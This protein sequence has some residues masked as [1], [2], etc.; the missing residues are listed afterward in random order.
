MGKT[1]WMLAVTYENF[2]ITRQNGFGTQGVEGSQRRKAARFAPDDRLLYYLSDRRAFAATATIASKRF[3]EH[4][5]VWKHHRE[6]EEFPFRVKVRP[7]VVL[8]ESQF[9]D[10]L[11][12]GPRLD[13]VRR[14]APEQWHLALMGPLHILPQRDFAFIEE[15]MKRVGSK[16]GR[17]RS[18][19]KR[20]GQGGR[21]RN[22]TRAKNEGGST[23]PAAAAPAAS[24]G[25]P[26]TVSA[27][28][29]DGTGSEPPTE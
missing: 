26:E 9:I 25:A 8:E 6:E 19:R 20:R 10:A 29:G 16:R 22:G 11:E 14:W 2:A 12:V 21:S 5:R 7:D 4:S 18:G 15:E 24:D 13:Y 17:R 23:P 1:Y 3:E 28:G 27:D